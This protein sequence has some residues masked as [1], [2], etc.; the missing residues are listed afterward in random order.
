MDARESSMSYMSTHYLPKSISVLENAYISI[1]SI[2]HHFK[3]IIMKFNLKSYWREILIAILIGLLLWVSSA[4]KSTNTVGSSETVCVTDTITKAVPSPSLVKYV[5]VKLPVYLRDTITDH[6][7]T[8]HYITQDT[9]WLYADIP[10]NE[11]RDTNYYIRTIGWMD[12]IS[13]FVPQYHVTT[14]SEMTQ[15][16]SAVTIFGNT[17][18]GNGV[19]APGVSISVR[20]L[21]LGYNYNVINQS[22]VVTVGYR[23]R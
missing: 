5:K 12:S 4:D 16:S 14:G 2:F 11:Y 20:K 7:I 10:Q 13:L 15:S 21:Q 23:I 8:D 18:M 1:I 3:I 6:K 19:V 22:G 9:A 17:M